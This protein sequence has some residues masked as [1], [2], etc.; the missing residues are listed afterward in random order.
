MRAVQFPPSTPSR[1]PPVSKH[2]KSVARKKRQSCRQDQPVRASVVE[3]LAQAG[4]TR[5]S[6][7]TLP[8]DSTTHG[9]SPSDGR[10]LV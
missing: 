4:V 3:R 2:L 7:S 1:T 10:L 6:Q 9:G 5:D 8:D